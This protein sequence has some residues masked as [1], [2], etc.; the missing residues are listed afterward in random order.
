MI[1]WY[2]WEKLG[3]SWAI[4]WNPNYG[5]YYA[6]AWKQLPKVAIVEGK[7]VYSQCITEHG[8]SLA[9]AQSRL[10]QRLDQFYKVENSIKFILL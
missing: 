6:Q 3:W 2:K 4:G 8:K 5:G 1:E 10:W 7:K 9:E